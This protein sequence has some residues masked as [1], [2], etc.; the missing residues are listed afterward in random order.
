MIEDKFSADWWTLKWFREE[1]ELG[2][3]NLQPEYQRSRVW[4]DEQ[5]FGLIDS[6]M[7]GF[8]I[9]LVMLNVIEH[10][11]DEVAVKK[12][13]VVDGQQR[14]RAV[15]E[16][17][18]GN[19][20]W[21]KQ[22][23]HEAFKPFSRLK[24]AMQQLIQGYKVP[25]ALMGKFDDEEINEIFSRLQE[26]KAL[27]PG[28]KLKALTTA[29][30]YPQIK[31]LTCHKI[32]DLGESRL[33]VRDGHWMLAAA[34]FKAVFTGELFARIE[35][36]NLQKF[37]KECKTKPS[38]SRK[39]LEDT[40]KIL[41]FES[42]VIKESLAIWPE[43]AKIAVTARALK[44]L[45]IALSFL[46]DEFALSGKEPDV[47][48]GV[49]GY[50]KSIGIERSPEWT[51]YLNTGRT[52]RVDTEAVKACI[53]ELCNR[54]INSSKAEPVDPKRDF[55]LSQREEIL[56]LAE[57]KCQECG[58][59]LSM[60][61]YHADHIKPHSKAGKTELANGRALCS[62]CNRSKGNRWREDFD[63]KHK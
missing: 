35:Y 37:I 33:K 30:I 27:K 5:R 12:Y 58:T 15:L 45:Y 48:Q 40:K 24:P 6:I 51:E 42:S 59:T 61:N 62:G 56:K 60:T 28:E 16:Y 22:E 36:I 4:N 47:A 10:V 53:A 57:H 63:L 46:L 7:Q 11:E 38:K 20:S 21:S 13:D 39:T 14:I 32:F 52:G 18:L 25:V 49:V 54:I 50:Y 2:H 17:L 8:P 43:F 44:W 31:D 55:T 29:T 1:Y 9:G 23:D 26:G 41:N 3:L 19:Q 34:F